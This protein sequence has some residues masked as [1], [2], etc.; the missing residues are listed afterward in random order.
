MTLRELRV[1][2]P[3]AFHPSQDWFEAE[4]FMDREIGRAH[5]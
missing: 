5:V 1:A 4:A 2:H 3:A